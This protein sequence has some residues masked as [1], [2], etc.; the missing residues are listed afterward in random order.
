MNRLMVS[1]AIVALILPA[2]ACAGEKTKSDLNADK[3]TAAAGQPAAEPASSTDMPAAKAPDVRVSYLGATDIS[4]K[5]LLGEEIYGDNGESIAHVA[6][7]LIDDDGS[8]DRIVYVTGG[9]AGVGGKKSAIDFDLVKIGSDEPST[10]TDVN[11]PL[12]R[13]SLTAE[14]L[15]SA[16]DFVQ[17]GADDYRMASELI[18]ATVDLASAPGDN[19]DAVVDDL[20]MTRDGHVKDVIVQRA[21]IGSI[22]GGDRYAY[23]FSLLSVEE[24]DGGVALNVTQEQLNGANKF[25]YKRSDAVDEAVETTMDPDDKN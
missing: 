17:D 20:I 5:A 22:G 15:K 14:Q 4:A 19:G 9:V 13:L 18:G 21:M 3:S 25:E 7:I 24:G 10:T 12:L 16:A 23:D 11:D 2:A 8:A 6:D 1:T